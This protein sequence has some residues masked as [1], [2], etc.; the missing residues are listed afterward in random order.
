[1]KKFDILQILPNFD[2]QGLLGINIAGQRPNWR[3]L[4]TPCIVAQ[5][6]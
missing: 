2:S 6:N 5:E 1:M 3:I 4:G